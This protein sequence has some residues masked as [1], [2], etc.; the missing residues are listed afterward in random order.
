[1]RQYHEVKNRFPDSL[2]LFQVGDFY[3]LFH[4]DAQKA[5]AF[6]GITLTKRGAINGEPIPLCGVP[7]HA[8]DH[9]LVKLVKGGFR[10]VLCDQMS[11]PIPGK[12]VERNVR[13]VLTPGTLTDM[14]MLEEKS[15]SYLACIFPTIDSYGIVFSELMTGQLFVTLLQSHDEKLLEAEL[16]RFL[17]DEIVIPQTKLGDILDAHVKK[18]GY[19]VTQSPAL[20]ADDELAASW[21]QQFP[22]SSLSFITHSE[23][24][25]SAL[26]LLYG[27]MKNNCPVALVQIR[28]IFTYAPDDFLMLDASTQRNL[29]LVK[30]LQDGSHQSTLFSVLDHASTAMGSRQIKK[31]ILR[32]LVKQEMIESRLD[33]IQA[34]KEA[35]PERNQFKDL[36]AC[37]GDLERVVGRIAL[38]RAQLYDYLGLTRAL[39]AMPT[40]TGV[41]EKFSSISMLALIK[42]RLADFTSLRTTLECSLN[43][44]SA[45]PWLI[46]SGY[47]AELDRLR[48]LLD[49]SAKAILELER[50]EQEASG[51]TS[52]KI[53]FNKAFGYAIEIT[54][55]HLDSVPSRY[56]RLQTLTNRERYTT[57][58]LKDLEYD[59]QRA[60][61]NINEVEQEIYNEIV[62]LVQRDVA[63]LKKS[64][65]ALA[66]LD[67]LISLAYVAYTNAYVRP[68]FNAVRDFIIVEGRHPVID[69]NLRHGFI[70]ND[71]SMNDT[72]SM[73]IIT[74][75]NMGGKST[76]LRQTALIC[77]LAQMG[78]FVPA[79][80]ARLPLVDRIFTR[81][82][83]ADNVAAGKSTFLVE[84]EEAALIC[85]QATRNSLVIL[86]EVGRG[87]ST[88]DGI[89]LAQAIIEYIYSH[90]QARCLFA[91]HY[92]ELTALVAHYPGIV[93]YHA[94]S[95]ETQEGVLLLHKIVKGT[96]DGSFGLEVAKRA[97]IPSEIIS[98]AHAILSTIKRV[99]VL[100]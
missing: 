22:E 73:W 83:A 78:S 8:V 77:V 16:A 65:Q 92:H 11:K 26:R 100:S 18:L 44:D 66:H 25:Q 69:M 56:L 58:E 39:Q 97:G 93:A 48:S 9:Y 50:K 41:M 24:M 52:L 40:I 90:I 35:V 70:P 62:A 80:F 85:T 1:M 57:Q 67:A 60:R 74:G 7:V 38:G 30:N 51:I 19:F 75:P 12:L 81:I 87:T 86:D 32:P 4:E 17:P 21:I 72:E 94:A 71:L 82:G 3:E 14:K 95:K 54:K 68:E 64:S 46:K 53:R 42:A 76:F 61:S 55:T 89:A 5:S 84:M 79:K 43:E 49:D 33:S 15:A 10:V 27:Y 6:L 34:L 36:L 63:A 88:Y 20:P 91:T 2:V 37:V 59:I 45:Q 31:W 28:Q 99:D 96:A 13:Q 29:E 23:A 47:N 98:R